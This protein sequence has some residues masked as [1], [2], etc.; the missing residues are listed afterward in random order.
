MLLLL[1]KWI[2]I[3]NLNNRISSFK[4][5]P[6]LFRHQT[7]HFLRQ[8]STLTLTNLQRLSQARHNSLRCNS[9]TR[10]LAL[11][12]KTRFSRLLRQP[13]TRF[14]QMHSNLPLHFPLSSLKTT[15]SFQ[16]HFSPSNSS[17]QLSSPS[18]SSNSGF[19]NNKVLDSSQF[20]SK[21]MDF[22]P[23]SSLRLSH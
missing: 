2:L 6:Q 14:S 1:K 16:L 3:S 23:I 22:N 19:N 20:S 15:L 5:L 17:H 8:V 12:T 4:D 10:D 21:V 13:R 9:T 7:I 11:T 18:L